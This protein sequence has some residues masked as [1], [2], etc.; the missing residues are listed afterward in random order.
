MENLTDGIMSD[1]LDE[2]ERI[3]RPSEWMHDDHQME[4]IA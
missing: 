3:S 4:V 2:R 1:D